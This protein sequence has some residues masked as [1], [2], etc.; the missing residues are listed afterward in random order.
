MGY[1]S[2][3]VARQSECLSW[4]RCSA[5]KGILPPIE[6]VF[7]HKIQIC[8]FTGMALE[9]LETIIILLSKNDVS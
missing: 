8:T 3:D 9:S 1:L 2:S 7:M 4:T 5:I 6:N